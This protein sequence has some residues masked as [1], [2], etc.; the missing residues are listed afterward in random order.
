LTLSKSRPKNIAPTAKS[1][2][3]PLTKMTKL[4]LLPKSN[5]IQYCIR[6]PKTKTEYYKN[7]CVTKY[8]VDHTVH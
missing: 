7:D 8:N 5:V 3:G 6:Y 4:N 2:D 1:N